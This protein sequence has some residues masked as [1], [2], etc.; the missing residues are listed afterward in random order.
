MTRTLPALVGALCALLLPAPI[1]SA[2]VEPNDTVHEGEV[3]A[4]APSLIT[5]TL[6]DAD[7]DTFTLYLGTANT[8]VRAAVTQPGTPCARVFLCRLDLELTE[9]LGERVEFAYDLGNIDDPTFEASLDVLVEQ[10]GTYRL[11]ILPAFSLSPTH[12]YTLTVD[13]DQPLLTFPPEECAA[14][15]ESRASGEAKLAVALRSERRWAAAVRTRRAY[16]RTVAR[17]RLAEARRHV[18]FHRDRIAAATETL[19]LHCGEL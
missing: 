7:V 14:A 19:R 15:R 8:R 2:E 18:R 17:R 5:G 4:L 12:P 3:I 10:P 11:R 16:A 6:G 13:A 1:A 9:R